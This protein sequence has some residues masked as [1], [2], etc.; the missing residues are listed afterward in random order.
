MDSRASR[1]RWV[2]RTITVFAVLVGVFAMHGL[3]MAVGTGC[4]GG[5]TAMSATAMSGHADSGPVAA[6][7]HHRGELCVFVQ[8]DAA[9]SSALLALAVLALTAF[10]LVL[11]LWSTDR[12]SRGP[13]LPSGAQ[14]LLRLS[15]SRT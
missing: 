6:P 7:A 13:P 12:P 14:L 15:V 1:H 10:A 4:H 2:I 3:P 8:P 5:S 9:D 11:G